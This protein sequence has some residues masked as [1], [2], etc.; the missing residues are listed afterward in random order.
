MVTR[1]RRSKF[2][3]KRM[4]KSD[5]IIEKITVIEYLKNNVQKIFEKQES[6]F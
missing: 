2:F 5:I 3:T 4:I 6:N 1:D